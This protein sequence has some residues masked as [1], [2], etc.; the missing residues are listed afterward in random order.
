LRVSRHGITD[1]AHARAP[2]GR[3][4]FTGA[5]AG[6]VTPGL[7]KFETRARVEDFWTGCLPAA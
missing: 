5:G 6:A 4:R 7:K 3:T 1:N 2:V